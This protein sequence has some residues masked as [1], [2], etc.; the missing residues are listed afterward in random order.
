MSA[1]NEMMA[2]FMIG[3]N[4]HTDR[5]RLVILLI[6]I[7]LFKYICTALLPATDVVAAR[8]VLSKAWPTIGTTGAARSVL[9]CFATRVCVTTAMR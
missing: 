3:A 4:N 5:C 1:C 7:A 8:I 2:A 9:C 6:V